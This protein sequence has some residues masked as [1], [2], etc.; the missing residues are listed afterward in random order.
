M[1]NIIKI[2]LYLC[3]IYLILI[4]F[5][6]QYIVLT[7]VSI[8][9]LIIIPTT[10]YAAAI[11]YYRGYKP[12]RFYLLATIFF[13]GG[14]ALKLIANLKLLPMNFIVTHGMHIG[15]VCDVTLLSIALADRISILRGE[16]EKAEMRTS[17]LNIQLEQ[18]VIERTAELKLTNKQLKQNQE[19]L[20]QSEKMASLGQLVAG[21]AHEINTPIGIALTSSS[22]LVSLTNKIKISIENNTIKKSDFEKYLS[23]SV[24]GNDLIMRNLKRTADLINSFK[25]VSAD[26][27]SQEIRRFNL[28]SYIEDILISLRPQLKKTL[29][30][31]TIQCSEDIELESNPGA[32]GQIITNLI[33]NSL[34]H[35]YDEKSD[36]G[37]III[38]CVKINNIILLKY[39]DDGKGIPEENIHKIF[40]PFFTT[41]RGS[42]GTGLGLHIVFN[43]VNQNLK[44]TIKC[45][46]QVGHGSTFFIELPI[47]L[48]KDIVSR[49]YPPL[50]LNK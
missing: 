17:L 14:G 49:P 9:G 13:F 23:D 15:S 20:V 34:I 44:G 3:G 10:F 1:D 25:M 43:I 2:L 22:H 5:M 35:G 42:G 27:T 50:G 30:V 16:K 19:K 12:A 29:H 18:K 4:F 26:Q 24:Q 31:I 28:K 33:M 32:L 48:I 41:R 6:P 39:S 47:I 8:M 21:V 46:S 45:E 36:K 40:D 38:S 11:C 7:I 37:N